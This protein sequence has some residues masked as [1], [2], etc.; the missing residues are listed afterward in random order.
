MYSELVYGAAANVDRMY[1]MALKQIQEVY[2]SYMKYEKITH[3]YIYTVRI[4]LDDYDNDDDGLWWD[5]SSMV[6]KF[7]WFR[8]VLSER[9]RFCAHAEYFNCY[10]VKAIILTCEP[11]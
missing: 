10:T 7:F 6:C 8:S 11:L 4:L 2:K 5:L 3:E 1:I 9:E